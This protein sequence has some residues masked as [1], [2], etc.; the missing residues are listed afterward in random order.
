M[1]STLVKLRID[2]SPFG[3]VVKRGYRYRTGTPEVKALD[4]F[5]VLADPSAELALVARGGVAPAAEV[6]RGVAHLHGDNRAVTLQADDMVHVVAHHPGVFAA[7]AADFLE[8]GREGFLE[9]LAVDAHVGRWLKREMPDHS[10]VVD[11]MTFNFRHI[12]LPC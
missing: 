9:V 8:R 12:Y 11:K 7:D 3:F 10:A 2:V 6:H 1:N 5:G 4:R